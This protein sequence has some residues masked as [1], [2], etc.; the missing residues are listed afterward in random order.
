MVKHFYFRFT[1][2]HVLE[3]PPFPTRSLS[4]PVCKPEM[5]LVA[6]P[7]EGETIQENWAK[8]SDHWYFLKIA[9]QEQP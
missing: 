5:T 6:S 2:L 9:F 1:C 8:I 3:P 4:V 7:C